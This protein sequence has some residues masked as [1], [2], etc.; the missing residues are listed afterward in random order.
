[1]FSEF[2]NNWCL[3]KIKLK[4]WEGT[5]NFRADELIILSSQGI[6]TIWAEQKTNKHGFGLS[7][8]CAYVVV[9]LRAEK[10]KKFVRF[11]VSA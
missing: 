9:I 4:V 3:L 10:Y 2:I 6:N 5:K 11:P 1:M 7:C 8:A